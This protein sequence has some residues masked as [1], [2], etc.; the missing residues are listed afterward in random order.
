MERACSFSLHSRQQQQDEAAQ[1]AATTE[2]S[3][4]QDLTRRQSGADNDF[5]QAY[6][7]LTELQLERGT[8]HEP[9]RR[10]IAEDGRLYEPATH[11]FLQVI[12]EECDQATFEHLRRAIGLAANVSHRD[13][14]TRMSRTKMKTRELRRAQD[15]SPL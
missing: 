10:S 3:D 2:L 9:E 5:H 6:S 1:H 14:I 4:S 12:Q 15:C 13:A 8:G 7:L 11:I